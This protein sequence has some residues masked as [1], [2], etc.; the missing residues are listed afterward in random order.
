M[1]I[2]CKLANYVKVFEQ[3]SK[4]IHNFKQDCEFKCKNLNLVIFFR[5]SEFFCESS[6]FCREACGSTGEN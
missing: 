2:F 1:I 4:Y 3:F 6:D 5:S